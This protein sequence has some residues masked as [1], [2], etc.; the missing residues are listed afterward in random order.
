MCDYVLKLTCDEVGI[1]S[2]HTNI[3]LLMN[4]SAKQTSLWRIKW[5]RRTSLKLAEYK[6][7]STGQVRERGML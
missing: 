2:Y 7:F 4:D 6:G 3:K 5:S 1:V